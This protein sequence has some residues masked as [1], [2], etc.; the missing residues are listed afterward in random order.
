MSEPIRL[1]Y[2]NLV[3]TIS[4]VFEESQSQIVKDNAF[5]IGMGLDIL[6]CYLRDIA[7]RA[8]E[9][10]DPVLIGLLKNLCI[11]AETEDDKNDNDIS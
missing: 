5:G 9:I 1:D 4:S 10:N 11:L 8:V 6:T 7:K 3:R 2:T